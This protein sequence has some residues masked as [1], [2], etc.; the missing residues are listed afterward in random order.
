MVA[1]L[2][3]CRPSIMASARPS[4]SRRR[5]VTQARSRRGSRQPPRAT[6]QRSTASIGRRRRPELD[7]DS[8]PHGNQ[9]HRG[10]VRD[11]ARGRRDGAVR[12]AGDLRAARRVRNDGIVGAPIGKVGAFVWSEA[13]LVLGAGMLLAAGLGWLLSKMLVA[14]LTHVFDPPPDALAIPW[15]FLA[16]LGGAALVAACRHRA[17]RTRARQTASRRGTARAVTD[18]HRCWEHN[19]PTVISPRIAI[20]EDDPDLRRVLSRACGRRTSRSAPSPP[21]PSCWRPSSSRSPTRSSSTSACPTPTGATSARRCAHA[22][23]RRRCCS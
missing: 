12:L 3:I 20:V 2:C 1:N 15:G 18:E 14:M 11:P 16:G 4:C 7:H 5:L 6:A 13:A 19:F 21:A 17:R 23:S 8:G 22:A 9:P 10:S